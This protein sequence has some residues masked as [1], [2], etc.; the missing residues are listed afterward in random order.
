MA[1]RYRVDRCEGTSPP[2]GM[3][4]LRYLGDSAEH[5]RKTLRE[6]EPGFDAWNQPDH[7]CGVLL[8]EWNGKE[9]VMV[10]RREPPAK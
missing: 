3:N 8:S 1:Y 9:Y 7:R 5:A 2:C 4:S 10:I 6:L